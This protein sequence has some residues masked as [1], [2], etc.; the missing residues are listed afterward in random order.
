M[1]FYFAGKINKNCW[2]HQIVG[3][4]RDSYLPES[5]VREIRMDEHGDDLYVGPFFMSCDHGCFHGKDTH[6]F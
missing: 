1:R 3:G 2:R 5:R 4:L 6:A